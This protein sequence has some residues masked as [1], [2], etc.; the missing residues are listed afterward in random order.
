MILYITLGRKELQDRTISLFAVMK[1]IT[2]PNSIE[3]KYEVGVRNR[4]E[5]KTYSCDSKQEAINEY[6]RLSGESEALELLEFGG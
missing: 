4:H 2:Y 3:T 6:S 5:Y 1:R